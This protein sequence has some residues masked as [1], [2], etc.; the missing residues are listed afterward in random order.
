MSHPLVTRFNVSYF[1]L[2]LPVWDIALV[3]SSARHIRLVYGIGANPAIS[4]MSDL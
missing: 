4:G 3:R 2:V 1:E